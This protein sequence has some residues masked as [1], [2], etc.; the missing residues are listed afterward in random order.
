MKREVQ[1]LT[2][3]KTLRTIKHRSIPST[4]GA[5]GAELYLLKNNLIMARR[6]EA[7]LDKRKKL[8][9]KRISDIEER[10]IELEGKA[11]KKKRRKRRAAAE[12]VKSSMRVVRI[13]Y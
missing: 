1:G 2:S 10:I 8:L 7:G 11:P 9:E 3:I 12:P 4:E 5:D 6:E 13:D